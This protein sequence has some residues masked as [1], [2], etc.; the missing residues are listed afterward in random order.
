MPSHRKLGMPTDQRMAVLKNQASNLL[1]YGKIETTLATARDVRRYTEKLI[2]VA[3]RNFE[4]I[5][6][7]EKTVLVTSK[8]GKNKGEKTPEKRIVNNDGPKKLAARRKLMAALVDLPDPM[9]ETENMAAYKIRTKDIKHPLIEKIFNELAPKYKDRETELKQ[10]GGYTRIVKLG[11]R[12]G[13]AAEMAI[14]EL[15]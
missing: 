10:G 5:A 3:V 8:K 7:V 6:K 2:T 11:M 4:D 15:V 13:D 9:L 1:W 14:I 12:R